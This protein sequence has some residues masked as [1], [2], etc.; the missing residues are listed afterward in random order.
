MNLLDRFRSPSPDK[1]PDSAVRLAYVESIPLDQ[2]ETIGSIAR[3]DADPR[4]RRAAVGKL[5]APA[6]LGEIAGA[7]PDEGVRSQAL[8]M[9]R[10]IALDAF[11]GLGDAEHFAAVDALTDQ[12]ALAQ[13]ARSSPR[14]AVGQRA[15]ARVADLHARGSI[16]RHG[17][18]EQVRLAAFDLVRESADTS[19]LV[20][21]ALNSEFR[22]TACAAVDS[23][24]RPR[25][26][27]P[28]G[29][30]R[31]EQER[32]ETCQRPAA[33]AGRTRSPGSGRCRSPR[34]AGAMG[35]RRRRAARERGCRG[36]SRRARVDPLVTTSAGR[37]RVTR[38]HGRGRL[39]IA[40]ALRVHRRAGCV[41]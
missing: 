27:G 38:R 18:S 25:Y 15:L 30:A 28:G 37:T 8:E 14:D 21:I 31:E 36:D 32:R 12:K 4:V 11:E 1:H 39:G 34:T 24:R 6:A 33:R 10:D 16:A 3:G 29:G 35:R 7:D 13:V 22:D 26:L 40:A 2:V 17:A 23:H 41:G 9:L 5:M 19:E 20:S